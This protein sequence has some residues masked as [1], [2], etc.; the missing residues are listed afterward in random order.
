MEEIPRNKLY[1]I[2]GNKNKFLEVKSMLP[3]VE[4]LE[5]DLEEIQETDAHKII[6]AKL[7]EAL[8]QHKGPF[9]VEDTSLYIK[10]LNGLPGPLIKWFLQKL[11]NEGIWRIS[12]KTFLEK[13]KI[14]EIGNDLKSN[15]AEAK[16]IIG[17]AKDADNIHF[18][19]GSIKGEIVKPTGETNFGWDPIFKP[20]NHNK[21]FQQMTKEEK[22]QV[23]MRKLA[24]E[25]LKEFLVTHMDF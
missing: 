1:F 6:Q 16:T 23:S 18:F 13:S 8:R 20:E 25:K 3:E 14:E 10:S 19:E 9:M 17:Y 12:D 2:T 24:V 15:L 5:L 21:S 22:N 7:K 4:Q 11:G